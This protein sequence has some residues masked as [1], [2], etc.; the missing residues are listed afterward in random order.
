LTLSLAAILRNPPWP[1]RQ[2]ATC[3]EWLAGQSGCDQ[4]RQWD[5]IGDISSAEIGG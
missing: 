1:E 5:L 3:V 2:P 4:G